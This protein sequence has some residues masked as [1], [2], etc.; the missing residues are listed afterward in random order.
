MDA[1][2]FLVLIG[3]AQAGF[4]LVQIVIGLCICNMLQRTSFAATYLEGVARGAGN[5]TE[6]ELDGQDKQEC[7]DAEVVPADE[8][9]DQDLPESAARCF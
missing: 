9:S 6:R 5:D 3:L 7:R 1:A 8:E 2:L 4:L